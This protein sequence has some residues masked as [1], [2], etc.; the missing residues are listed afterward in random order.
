VI[1]PALEKIHVGG[2]SITLPGRPIAG[3]PSLVPIRLQAFLKIT[4]MIKL[5]MQ[6]GR[7]HMKTLVEA[8]VIFDVLCNRSEF[9]EASSRVWNY[10]EVNQIEGNFIMIIPYMLTLIRKFIS[11]DGRFYNNKTQKDKKFDLKISFFKIHII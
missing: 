10:C 3:H 7:N 5:F 2:K 4:M 6:T 11:L 1:S 9:G 8:N